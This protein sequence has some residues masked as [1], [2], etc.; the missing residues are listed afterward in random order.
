MCLTGNFRS[1]QLQG[2]AAET[3]GRV[4]DCLRA[5]SVQGTDQSA[6]P[7]AGVRLVT[8][9]ASREQRQHNYLSPPLQTITAFT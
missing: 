9:Q 7:K 1:E 8:Q 5:I 6:E 3:Q 2:D 4:K